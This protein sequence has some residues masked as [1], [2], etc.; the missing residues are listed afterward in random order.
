M[1]AA[2][3][4]LPIVN[5]DTS[6]FHGRYLSLV[7]HIESE[8]P[9]A[10]WRCG[11]VDVWPL[12]RMDLYLDMY[13]Q[14]VGRRP[15]KPWPTPIRFASRVLRP[16]VNLWK[17]RNDL[18]HFVQMPTPSNAI[19]LGDGVSLDRVAGA[20]TD[21]F[22]EPIIKA[23]ESDGRTTFLMQ[24]GGLARLPW[25]RPTYCA[26]RV[27]A[28]AWRKS[29]AMRT[30]P[31]L[32]G[33]GEILRFLEHADV[34]APSLSSD[35]LKERAN[36]VSACAS[37]FERLFDIVNP[38]IAFVVTYYAH[39]GHAFVLA[40]RRRAI[41]SV[42]LQHDPQDGAHEAYVWRN[43]PGAGYRTLPAVFW[44]WT[45]NDSHC[46]EQW[47]RDLSGPWHRSICGGHT[48]L[49]PFLDDGERET[50]IWDEDF[51]AASPGTF[52]REILIAL[53]PIGGYRDLWR[54]LASKIEE[55]PRNWRWWIRRHPASNRSQDAEYAALLA[56]SGSNIRLE[57]ASRF[58]LPVLLRNIDMVLSLSSGA[59]YE[60]AMFDIPALFLCEAAGAY[61][62]GLIQSGKAK[63]IDVARVID[64]IAQWGPPPR[65]QRALACPRI[66]RTLRRL[67]EMADEYRA[68]CRG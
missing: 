42:D 23:L 55:A 48:Q 34:R 64:E 36:F 27:E 19:F 51:R 40:C 5:G 62:P 1:G 16:A 3:V 28:R 14:Q 58:P 67:D 66:E 53:Q 56:L 4:A 18:D 52:E 41:L 50:R 13:W 12:A 39:L 37:E 15:P 22:G 46:I 30:L 38:K 6:S 43:P 47:T 32:P 63:I 57:E 35:R 60:G 9:V 65:K 25:H 59:A 20:W 33:H 26:N 68:A 54:T 49:A 44:N 24:S 2:P 29:L 8:F 21:R 17:S 61:F 10:A 45:E 7:S 11:D 31:D